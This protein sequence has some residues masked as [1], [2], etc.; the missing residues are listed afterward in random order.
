[1]V[2]EVSPSCG[3]TSRALALPCSFPAWYFLPGENH[4]H[5]RTDHVHLR[6]AARGCVRSGDMTT[7]AYRQRQRE[8]ERRHEQAAATIVAA[9]CIVITL[10]WALTI[11]EVLL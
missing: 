7:F 1:M 3:L 5:R 2:I 10:A 9:G 6:P 8:L 4:V 11:L